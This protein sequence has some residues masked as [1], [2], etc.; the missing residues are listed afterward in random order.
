MTEACIL[1]SWRRL[2]ASPFAPDVRLVPL[3]VSGLRDGEP[4]SSAVS[5]TSLPKAAPPAP[6]SIRRASGNIKQGPP[7]PG[8]HPA[9][10]GLRMERR[11]AGQGSEAGI[12]PDSARKPERKH[13]GRGSMAK[14]AKSVQRGGAGAEKTAGIETSIREDSNSLAVEEYPHI[15]LGNFFSAAGKGRDAVANGGGTGFQVVRHGFACFDAGL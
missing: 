5:A 12:S 10:E 4:L 2:S 13:I 14:P 6:G 3:G 9:G 1:V 15:L 8:P 7:R 11:R